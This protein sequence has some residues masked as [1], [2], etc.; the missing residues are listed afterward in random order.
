MDRPDKQLFQRLT[1]HHHTGSVRE[2]R[3]GSRDGGRLGWRR[4]A[5]SLPLGFGCCLFVLNTMRE[6][7]LED[8]LSQLIHNLILENKAQH[9]SHR[10]LQVGQFVP[11]AYM[12]PITSFHVF[13]KLLIKET[14]NHI[15]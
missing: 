1:D 7:K 5:H 12:C 13:T 11:R 15:L 9:E 8:L 2:R 14:E 6:A 3:L 10:E 4:V